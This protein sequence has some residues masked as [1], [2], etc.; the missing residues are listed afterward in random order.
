[1]RTAPPPQRNTFGPDDA[2]D[3][4]L[5]T[6]MGT[7]VGGGALAA[8]LASLPAVLRVG[9]GG[10]TGRA[11]DE[12]VALSAVLMPVAIFAVGVFRR[13]RAGIKLLAGDSVTAVASGVLWWAVIETAFLSLVGTGLRAKTH[14]HGLAGV[15]FAMMALFSGLVVALLA[16]R[17]TKM[18]AKASGSSQRAGLIVSAGCAFLVIMLIGMRTAKSDTLHTAAAL[19]DVLALVVASA[20][21]SARGFSLLKPLALAGVPVAVIVFI[22]GIV[23]YRGNLGQDTTV[24]AVNAP[25][26]S[27]IV[28][29]V[30]GA[31]PS[32]DASQPEG[33]EGDKGEMPA[34]SASGKPPMGKG[35][36]KDAR[37]AS[38]PR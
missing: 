27:W 35:P 18:I 29:L 36:V 16:V 15:T 31:E 11:V 1:M 10:S 26:H 7:V 30:F 17:A 24:L 20:I 32:K 13:A 19:V 22:L 28:G 9:D 2:D 33:L 12:W 34:S 4:A 21:A 3:G 23:S 25:F 8:I 6:R 38:A 5:L 14:H 37:D